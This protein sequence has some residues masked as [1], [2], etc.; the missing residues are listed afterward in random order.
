MSNDNDN[1]ILNYN[2]ESTNNAIR[3]NMNTTISNEVSNHEETSTN[4]MNTNI[5]NSNSNVLILCN[6]EEIKII[7]TSIS[8]DII[9]GNNEEVGSN[10]IH[11]NMTNNLNGN[12]NVNSN[13]K[14]AR[15][16]MELKDLVNKFEGKDVNLIDIALKKLKKILVTN[17]MKENN[18]SSF[19]KPV[20]NKEAANK[21]N[22][23][24]RE[25]NENKKDN[26]ERQE[27]KLI[28]A[29]QLEKK[30]IP[31]PVHFTEN[32]HNYCKFE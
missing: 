30:T 16:F 10:V 12:D 2:E 32:Y 24:Q 4:V 28:K 25:L 8:D 3:D 31:I 22:S 17:K 11:S 23:I 21:K 7:N 9:L 27:S 6:N 26:V 15:K 29:T 5:N 18:V 14:N 1:V 20:S 19:G 13:D